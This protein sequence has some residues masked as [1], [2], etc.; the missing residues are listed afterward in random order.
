[1]K[2]KIKLIVLIVIF[3]AVLMILNNLL[4]NNNE[5]LQNTLENEVNNSVSIEE[6]ITTG[7]ISSYNENTAAGFFTDIVEEEKAGEVF[8]V[9]EEN[10]TEMVLKSDKKV[11]IEFYADWCGPC[12]TL[13]PI[14]E[15][16]AKENLDIKVVKINVDEN[17]YLA[18]T[19]GSNYLPYL[20]VMEDAREINFAVGAIP[21]KEILELVK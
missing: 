17:P 14:L 5:P 12:K 15:E 20:V 21:K 19:F 1:M 8:E 9:T 7:V 11:L 3:I 2:E 18:T 10:F 16:I 4:N 13:S 6:N